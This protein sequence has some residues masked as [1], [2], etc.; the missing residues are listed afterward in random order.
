MSERNIERLINLGIAFIVGVL[1][2][3]HHEPYAAGLF[4]LAILQRMPLR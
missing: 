2:M 1:M 3:T 4:T